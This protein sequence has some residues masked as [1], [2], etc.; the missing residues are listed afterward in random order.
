MRAFL[1][2]W[3]SRQMFRREMFFGSTFAELNYWH[4]TT[5]SHPGPKDDTDDMIDLVI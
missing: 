3:S 1:S 2:V 4:Q 5:L